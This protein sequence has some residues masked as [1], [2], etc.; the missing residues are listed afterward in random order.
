MRLNR[1]LYSPKSAPN[2]DTNIRRTDHDTN[3]INS[4]KRQRAADDFTL[5]DWDR[6]EENVNVFEVE[7]VLNQGKFAF[8]F[9]EGPLVHA[10]RTGGWWVIPHFRPSLFIVFFFS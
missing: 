10:L 9:I 7:H 5:A 4:R 8:A 3:E 1:T 2:I 6:F